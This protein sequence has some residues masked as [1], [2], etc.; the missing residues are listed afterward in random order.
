[1]DSHS[2][3]DAD[4]LVIGAGVA[5]LSCAA[6]LSG[7]GLRVTVLEALDHL[8]GRAASWIDEITGD[9]VDIGPHV[10]SSEH[11]NFMALLERLGT[12]DLIRWQPDPLIT[13][14]DARRQ[15]RMHAPAWPPPLH[16]LPNLRNALRCL[17]PGDLLS[18]LRVA[19]R[20]ARL[21]AAGTQALDGEDGHSF[22]RRQGVSPRA[23]DWFW[24]SSM[25]AVLNVPLE[26]CSAAAMMRVF[27]LMLGRSGYCF[28]F[29]KVG[30]SQLFAPGCRRAVEAAGGEVATGAAV[31]AISGMAEGRFKGVV[32]ADGRTLRAGACV[33][34]VPPEA[35]A[36]LGM[37]AVKL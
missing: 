20:A 37:P 12:A 3:A 18:N 6:A 29:P 9:T 14:L 7:C 17:G 5:G 25:L 13:L 31:H 2:Q 36:A 10:V 21:D 34:A 32:L 26:A 4:V 22:L 11:R 8:G 16:G 15:L 27:R 28:G 24:R 30:L 35:L 1:M 23:I 19:W 33:L